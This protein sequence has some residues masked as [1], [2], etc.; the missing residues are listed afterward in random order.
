MSV[1]SARSKQVYRGR[2]RLAS[3]C[4]EPSVGVTAYSLCY[5]F[6]ASGRANVQVLAEFLARCTLAISGSQPILH[7]WRMPSSKNYFDT[8]K[9]G[10]GRTS[11]RVMPRARYLLAAESLKMAHLRTADGCAAHLQ[12]LSLHL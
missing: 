12:A 7:A 9:Q 5:H 11:V 8:M 3:V 2:K 10:I 4:S 1:S 6:D